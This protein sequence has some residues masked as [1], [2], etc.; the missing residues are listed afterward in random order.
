[1]TI[2]AGFLAGI[3]DGRPEAS[4][5]KRIA[6]IGFSMTIE[7]MDGFSRTQP[8]AGYRQVTMYAVRTMSGASFPATGRHFGGRD[9]TTVIHACERVRKMPNLY[10]AY[11]ALCAEVERQWAIDHGF[12][13]HT[14]CESTTGL[15]G[16]TYEHLEDLWREVLAPELVAA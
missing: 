1:M 15:Y 5:V 9:H 3:A 12:D 2:D 8:L 6:A 7:E 16:E 4:Y 14:D 11:E 10:R 13:V